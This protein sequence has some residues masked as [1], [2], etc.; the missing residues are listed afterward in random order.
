MAALTQR[1]RLLNALRE[2]GFHGLSQLDFFAPHVCDGGEPITRIAARVEEL[3]DAGY[4]ITSAKEPDRGKCAVYRL[5]REPASGPVLAAGP[6]TRE[7]AT[8]PQP[9]FDLGDEPANAIYEDAA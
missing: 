9:L 7:G 5:V 4:V 2:R 1:E 8:D 3:R 6:H